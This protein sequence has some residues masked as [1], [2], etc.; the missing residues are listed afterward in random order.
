MKKWQEIWLYFV[1]FYSF[2]HIIRDIFQDLGIENILSTFLASSGAPK[3]S[4]TIYWTI[5]NTYVIASV[6]IVLALMCLRRKY[7]G[8]L[9]NITI[10]IA[11]TSAILWSFYYFYL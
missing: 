4:A 6:E 7:F 1:I 5:F 3:V 8:L 9:G 2:L 10:V 11:V